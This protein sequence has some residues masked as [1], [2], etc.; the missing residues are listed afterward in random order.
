MEPIGGMYRPNPRPGFV[1]WAIRRILDGCLHV[2]Y[3]LTHMQL[4]RRTDR[5][6]PLQISVTSH[7]KDRSRQAMSLDISSKGLLLNYLKSNTI[8]TGLG[9]VGLEFELPG[10]HEIVWA[11]GTVQFEKSNRYFHRSGIRFVSIARFHQRLISDYLI[12][13]QVRQL[14]DLLARVRRNRRTHH[15]G[16]P[17]IGY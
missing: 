12:D 8:T 2:G 14:R 3:Y 15:A 16:A 13:L 11:A 1:S 9:P 4:H 6:T 10:V 7:A 5:R 17:R